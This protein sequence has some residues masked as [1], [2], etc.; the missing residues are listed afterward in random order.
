MY[1]LQIYLIRKHHACSTPHII[2]PELIHTAFTGIDNNGSTTGHGRT[3]KFNV[4]NTLQCYFKRRLLIVGGRGL[5][6]ALPSVQN[7]LRN[8]L[9]FSSFK[10]SLKT[11]LSQESYPSVWAIFRQVLGMMP[12]LGFLSKIFLVF[13]S[14]VYCYIL[15]T[16]LILFN[17]MVYNAQK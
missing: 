3:T 4:S 5:N 2:L 6:H 11:F 15:S 12:R 10:S 1:I 13:L 9:S 17:Y 16:D 7:S 14:F 8:I